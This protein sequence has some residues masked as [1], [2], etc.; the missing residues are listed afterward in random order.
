MYIDEER[1]EVFIIRPTLHIDDHLVEYV[2][3]INIHYM[4]SFYYKRLKI[5]FKVNPTQT[6][7]R[8]ISMKAIRVPDNINSQEETARLAYLVQK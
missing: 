8:D 4:R 1:E 6:R 3:R 5:L 2:L 7:T